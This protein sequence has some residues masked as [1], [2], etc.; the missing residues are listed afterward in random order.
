MYPPVESPDGSLVLPLD[1]LRHER[2]GRGR[3]GA[4]LAFEADVLDPVILQAK[5]DREAITAEWV[6]TLRVRVAR[7]DP[8]EVPRTPVV[9]QNDVAIE[10]F[11]VHQPNTSRALRRAA[12]RLATSASVL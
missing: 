12:T 11:E 7:L 1:G 10:L 4:P 3:D 9:V 5:P 6:V 8:A 2:S